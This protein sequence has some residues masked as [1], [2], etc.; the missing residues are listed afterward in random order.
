MKC[1]LFSYVYVMN[2]KKSSSPFLENGLWL[3][4]LIWKRLDP[5]FKSEA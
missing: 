3:S 5:K 2:I 1:L 4:S